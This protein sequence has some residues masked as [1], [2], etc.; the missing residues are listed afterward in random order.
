MSRRSFNHP[1]TRIEL[2]VDRD[3]HRDGKMPV[4]TTINFD[5]KNNPIE[6]ENDTSEPVRL[7]NVKGTPKRT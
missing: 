4:T 3:G 6:L 5:R 7:Q 2:N 1:F